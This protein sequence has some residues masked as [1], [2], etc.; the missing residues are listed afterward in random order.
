MVNGKAIKNIRRVTALVFLCLIILSG[1]GCSQ[2]ADN[3]SGSG[4]NVVV[5][6]DDEFSS[7]PEV[8]SQI[9]PDYTLERADN[10]PFRN[11]QNGKVSEAF[12]P[13]AVSALETGAAKH[14]YPQYLA[15]V[16]IAVD[17]ELTDA[18]ISSWSDLPGSG[19]A[20]GFSG[21]H[22]LSYETL[23]SAV[24]YG[25]TGE[26]YSLKSAARLLAA[27]NAQGRLIQNS[28]ESPILICYD[29]A[30]A[31]LIKNGRKLEIIVPAEGTLSY[32]KGLLS[33]DE[34][35]FSGDTEAL[36]LSNGFRLLNGC[37]DTSLYPAPKAYENAHSIKD[38]TNFSTVSYDATRIIRRDVFGIRL[39][40][41]ADGRENQYLV[42]LYIML[43]AVWIISI[44]NRAVQKGVRRAALY[45]GI[46]LIGWIT[47]RLISWTLDNSSF[48]NRTFWYSYYI[49]QLSLPLI[50]L[51]LAW[52]I[53]KPE[54]S[55]ALPIWMRAVHLVNAV[56][57]LLVL[58]NNLH[59]LV[60]IPDMANP[61]WSS[62]YTYTY[63]FVFYLV[64]A[65][66]W[67]PLVSGVVMLLYKGRHGLRKR[68]VLFVLALFGLLATYAIGYML[69][70]PIAWESDL[71]MTI[72]VFVLL[73]FEACIRSGMI[74][75]N[76]KYVKL[77]AHSPLSMQITNKS[78]TVVLSSEYAKTNNKAVY[79]G[80]RVPSRIPKQY[81]E[82]TLLFSDE[83]TGGYVYWQEDI[84]KIVMLHKEI[85]ESVKKL[86]AANELLVK[87]EAI[88][89]AVSEETARTQLMEQLEKEISAHITRLSAMIERLYSAEDPKKATARVTLLLAYIKRR[90]NLFFRE[91]ESDLFN[92]DELT[93]YM[94]ELSGMAGYCGIQIIFTCELNASVPVRMATVFY[95]FFYNVLDWAAGLSNLR[96]LAHLGRESGNIVLRMLPSED[97][98]SFQLDETVLAAILAE[99]GCYTVKELDND[100][101]GI[102][103]S[104][105][106]GGAYDG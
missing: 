44:I 42:L 24:A 101:S 20:V 104:L 41:A 71:T 36:L 6:I 100:A 68:G 98:R 7:Y 82:T 105:P 102:S 63:G 32:E 33:T 94:D 21:K 67:I 27:L 15:T 40:S 78:D 61:K 53:D 106:E 56:L 97:A 43:V 99:N 93:G 60:F 83:I 92:A 57:L 9:L 38:Y 10:S 64:Q 81:N 45:T 96:I 26:G 72:G 16:V 34:L 2:S 62:T 76:S 58:S 46:V 50:I 74:P 55:Q 19:E 77:F 75:V 3:N 30:A 35:T 28:Y 86:K 69:R 73:L 39:Y 29:Y 59:H 1:S 52:I 80:S 54:S 8:L 13:H 90:C 84:S 22:L 4:K 103:L 88:K 79:A 70:I 49:F 12:D 17:R 23:M 91:R 11:L 95:D 89:R 37:C 5:C 85:E 66:C 31:R 87:E 25:L 48:F 65:G 18:K 47:A 51:W 14:W